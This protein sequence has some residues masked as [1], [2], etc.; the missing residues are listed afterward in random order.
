MKHIHVIAFLTA[1][2]LIAN[3]SQ[4]P[5]Q[6]VQSSPSF[7]GSVSAFTV[8]GQDLW[9]G[10]YGTSTY[11][12]G[13]S[14]STD[15]GTTWTT[16]DQ[17]VGTGTGVMAFAVNGSYIFA[18]TAIGVYATANNGAKW[19]FDMKGILA[20]KFITSLAAIGTNL[21]AGTP[22]GVFLTTDNGTSWTEADSGMTNKTVNSL[23]VSGTS[24]FAGTSGGG[25]FCS[26]NNASSWTAVD[27][28]L[29]N[30]FVGALTVNGSTLYAVTGNGGYG[31]YVFLSTNNGAS[32]TSISTGLPKNYSISSL[33]VSGT[34]LFAGA[35][36]VYALTNI[37]GSWTSVST[38]LPTS[39]TV[40][41]LVVF[42]SNLFAGKGGSV[43]RR[44]LS[45]IT[46]VADRQEA[47]PSRF[48]LL[49]NYPNPFN[50]STTICY[51]LP[52]RSYVGLAVYNSL[53]QIV[54]TL[55]N[56]EE[57]SGIHEVKFDGSALASG[58]YFYR[59]QSGSF[60]QS[61]RFVLM[62]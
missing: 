11:D 56:G 3:C 62:K 44:P 6:W 14:L 15:N 50:P 33:V 39:G 40:G 59:L 41:A 20:S 51:A 34:T 61:R 47:P 35:N 60:V 58:V 46:S 53:G 54:T 10:T 29:T 27:S 38:G 25:V 16:I 45:E 22:S 12:Y 32:W 1:A 52:Q 13:V 9:A 17:S 48:E 42:G 21:F 7:T 36:G 43:Y 30:H 18:G 24:L 8:V 28:G 23:V 2:L 19:S 31:S 4:A 49:Q 57:E 37:G 55:V 26:T 5:A